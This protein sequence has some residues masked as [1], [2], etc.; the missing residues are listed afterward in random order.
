MN[1]KDSI[2]TDIKRTVAL[3][4]TM[5]LTFSTFTLTALAAPAKTEVLDRFMN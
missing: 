3:L 1:T 5:I 4:G 2:L